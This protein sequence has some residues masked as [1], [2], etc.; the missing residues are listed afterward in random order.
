M[1]CG[2]FLKKCLSLY[3]VSRSFI[4]VGLNLLAIT[5]A[6]HVVSGRLL[7]ISVILSV[8]GLSL[9][10]ITLSFPV[11]SDNFLDITEILP[12]VSGCLLVI[13]VSLLVNC[14]NFLILSSAR[15]LTCEKIPKYA[16]NCGRND[17]ER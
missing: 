2:V 8:V 6:L 7:V 14:V 9:L 10:V 16:R 13:T 3:L 11:V 4:I 15:C 1:I 17:L 12:V 5:E